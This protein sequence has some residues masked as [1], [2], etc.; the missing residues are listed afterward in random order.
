[1]LI[2]TVYLDRKNFQ[3]KQILERVL[4]FPNGS[5]K[6]ENV[7]A[8]YYRQSLISMYSGLPIKAIES[9]KV[10]E[11]FNSRNPEIFERMGSAYY[12]SGQ[13]KEA[14]EAWKRALY[15]S[16]AEKKGELQGFIKNAEKQVNENENK[17]KEF[18]AKSQ[19]VSDQEEKKV[20]NSRV[21]RI[22]TDSNKA[23]SYAQEV[24]EQMPNTEVFVEELE[25][26][27][28]AVKISQ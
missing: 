1:M 25:N 15:L 9:L 7:E 28:W 13:P 5:F 16:P 18:L 12:S 24:R 10:L 2:Q 21:L 6:V 17:V 11:S 4:G 8:K 20:K 22:L 23:Y 26:G 14:I 19:E 3:A 27:K